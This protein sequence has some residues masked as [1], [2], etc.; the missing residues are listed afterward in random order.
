MAF[1]DRALI[2]VAGAPI[3]HDFGLSDTQFGLMHGMAFVA[4]YCLCGIPMGW[5]ADCVDRRLMIA[6]ALLFWSVMTAICGLAGSF[7]Q[8]FMARIGVGLGEAVLVPAGMSLLSSVVSRHRMARSV[9]IFLMGAALGSSIALLGG[10]FLLNHFSAA[11][12]LQGQ[13]EP[14]QLL[15]L[16]ACVPGLVLAVVFALIREPPRIRSE[17]DPARFSS[18]VVDALSH[19]GQFKKAYGFLTAATACSV[20]LAQAQAAWVPLL[21]VRKFGLSAGDSAIWLGIMF[22]ISAPIGQWVGGL[23]IDWLYARKVPAPSN[24]VLASCAIAAI[25]PAYVFCSSDQLWTSRAAYVLFNFLVFAATPAGLTGWQQLTPKR[26]AG[27][28]IAIL[29]SVVTLVGV[30]IGPALVGWLIDRVFQSEAA[31]G[32]ALFLVIAV[33]A[34][35]CCAF[36]ISGRKAYSEALARDLQET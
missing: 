25:L 24:V 5:I 1:I 33:T 29:V 18:S 13:Y 14:W 12:P 16:I 20:L 8:F 7:S 19:L 11:N 34:V 2:G 35:L 36:S 28:T 4:L 6:A 3:K 10:G 30:D 31:I 22:V 17:A 26:M 15:F 32:Y 23:L 21:Y 9:A 27:L